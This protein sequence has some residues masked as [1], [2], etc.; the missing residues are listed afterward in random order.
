MCGGAVRSAVASKYIRLLCL[1]VGHLCI[2]ASGGDVRACVRGR[3]CVLARA[4]A[5]YSP[6]MVI[7][8]RLGKLAGY[9]NGRAGAL[10]SGE[11]WEM[12]YFWRGKRGI[13]PIVSCVRLSFHKV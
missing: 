2:R 5:A 7:N 12:L 13:A 4:A 1:F 9:E 6:R 8:F 10:F 3:I 11:I